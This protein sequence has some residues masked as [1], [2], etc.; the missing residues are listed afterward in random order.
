MWAQKNS[1]YEKIFVLMICRVSQIT[2]SK[3]KLSH[4]VEL[5]ADVHLLPQPQLRQRQ[6]PA[7]LQHKPHQQQVATQATSQ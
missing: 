6:R 3:S 5:P 1:A 4:E 7:L 2:S